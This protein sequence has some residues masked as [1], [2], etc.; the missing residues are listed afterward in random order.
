[1]ACFATP[2]SPQPRRPLQPMPAST[3]AA[4]NGTGRLERHR[5]NAG[6]TKPP[7][8]PCFSPILCIW[9]QA[10]RLR[11]EF[12][13]GIESGR[14]SRRQP[15]AS[16]KCTTPPFM[17]A[18]RILKM[19]KQF[20]SLC[21]AQAAATRRRIGDSCGLVWHWPSGGDGIRIRMGRSMLTAQKHIHD[22]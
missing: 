5:S 7:G 9:I 12:F 21:Y 15:N 19:P 3:R 10:T 1:M 22:R 13:C 4:P 11:D 18:L 2:A 14:G 8:Q 17:I 20:S 16:G 6:R